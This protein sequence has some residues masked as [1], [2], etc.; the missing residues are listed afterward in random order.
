ME[1]RM[2][3]IQISPKIVHFPQKLIALGFVLCSVTYLSS[4]CIQSHMLC[5][6]ARHPMLLW[7]GLLSPCPWLLPREASL[8]ASYQD[9]CRCT[10]DTNTTIPMRL[11]M[12][13]WPT[14]WLL[15][16]AVPL[17]TL[18]SLFSLDVRLRQDVHIVAAKAH[19]CLSGLC[20]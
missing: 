9:W 13:C 19:T 17:L 18:P 5:I 15:L 10:T 20:S 11:P 4:V 7:A 1:G 14:W 2:L 3:C 6:Q 16:V 12:Q 8:S